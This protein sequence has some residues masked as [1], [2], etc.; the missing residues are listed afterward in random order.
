MVITV[1]DIILRFFKNDISHLTIGTL[2]GV[3]VGDVAIY[4][5]YK[6]YQKHKQRTL[7]SYFIYFYK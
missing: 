6:K 1:N 2:R 3:D 7:K 5:K 4:L